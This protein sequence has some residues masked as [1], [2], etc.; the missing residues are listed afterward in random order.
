MAT[1]HGQTLLFSFRLAFSCHGGRDYS[2][3]FKLQT[4]PNAVLFFSTI[5]LRHARLSPLRD[6]ASASLL[7]PSSVAT[8]R[9][10]IRFNRLI[11]LLLLGGFLP[12]SG[13]A[14]S[15]VKFFLVSPSA[16][17]HGREA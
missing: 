5:R 17:L 8:F 11:R 4:L 9:C 2:L 13:C 7:H 10:P 12:P 6:T 1:V 16:L 15:G 3:R 14:H